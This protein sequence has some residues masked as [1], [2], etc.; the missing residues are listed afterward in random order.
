[1]SALLWSFLFSFSWFLFF[2]SFMDFSAR[3]R[4]RELVRGFVRV[5]FVPSL[6]LFSFSADSRCFRLKFFCFDFFF[7]TWG[8]DFLSATT[9]FLGSGR[10]IS[11]P[12]RL[13]KMRPCSQPPTST[14]LT[15]RCLSL[16]TK[17]RWSS[18]SWHRFCSRR[19][20]SSRSPARPPTSLT[21]CWSGWWD[22]VLAALL[23]RWFLWSFRSLF[24][25]IFV[26][27]VRF[28]LSFLDC[29]FVWVFIVLVFFP[30]SF[31]WLH[32]NAASCRAGTTAPIRRSTRSW[33]SSFHASPPIF[34][35]YQFTQQ[36]SRCSSQVR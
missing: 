22:S 32:Q 25:C 7:R 24:R 21:S 2:L 28:W 6:G 16:M 35:F 33:P 4:F 14:R 8:Q 15:T 10:R 19:W 9:T 18:V 11:F 20:I 26:E 17:H 30:S 1:M 27:C 31:S 3:E 29:S 12:G 5:C 36:I 34:T 23:A 13:S